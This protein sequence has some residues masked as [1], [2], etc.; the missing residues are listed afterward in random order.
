[1]LY[2]F[3][4]GN[5]AKKIIEITKSEIA[6]NSQYSIKPIKDIDYSKIKNRD[7][8]FFYTKGED[9][10]LM[11]AYKKR[12]NTFKYK[13]LPKY[14]VCQCKTR[15]EYNDF[16]YASSMPVEVYCRDQQKRIEGLQHLKLCSNCASASQKNFYRLLAKG[17]PWYEYVIQYASTQNEIST[18]TKSN[19]YVVMWKQISEAIRERVGFCCEKC[20]INLTN[21]S[22]YLEVHHKD[23]IKTNNSS[24][25]LIALCVLCHA[26]V[27]ERHLSNF[28][29]EPLK[30][31]S[32][33]LGYA[34]YIEK[35]NKLGLQKWNDQK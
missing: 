17:K 11:F 34:P 35:Y 33:K 21:E 5:T 25:N 29:L 3:S 15:I 1:M 6:K 2:D 18:K 14:H 7:K 4:I 23:F 12:Y 10:F 28:R 9:V 30:V 19:G 26:T 32:F 27:D 8:R 22:Y 20:N 24:N 31:E 13:T 16:T